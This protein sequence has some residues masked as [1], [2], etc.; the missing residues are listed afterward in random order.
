MSVGEGPTGRSSAIIRQH[1]SNELTARMALYSLRVFQD[2]EERIGDECGFTP[3]GF[4]V[5]VEAKDPLVRESAA[6][7]LG[8]RGGEHAV[9]L[10]KE[11]LRKDEHKWVRARA[12]ESLGLLGAREATHALT[13]ALSREKDQRVRRTVAWDGRLLIIGFTSGTIPQAPTNHALLKNYSIVGVHWG[14]WLARDPG[15]LRSNWERIVE[16]VGT[17]HIDPLISAV[18]PFEE[19]AAA[20]TDLGDRRTVGK[21][22][23]ETSPG[24]AEL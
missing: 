24:A 14:A 13:A 15:N 21:V 4:V 7:V 16:L 8:H 1:Y 6:Q 23:I 5:L 11:R 22:V 18:R 9:A 10:L 12:A 3:A 20:L 17:G 19:A 2:F